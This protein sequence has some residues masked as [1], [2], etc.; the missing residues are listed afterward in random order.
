VPSELGATLPVVTTIGD[1]VVIRVDD[2]V[3]MRVDDGERMDGVRLGFGDV[4]WASAVPQPNKATAR[5]VRRRRSIRASCVHLKV[6]VRS[7]DRRSSA[8][9]RPRWTFVISDLPQSV[10]RA[11]CSRPRD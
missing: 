4:I 2:G 5:R 10:L 11:P 6:Y 7:F 8:A 1:G 9:D 3:V